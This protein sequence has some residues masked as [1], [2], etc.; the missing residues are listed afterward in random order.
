MDSK[1]LLGKILQR[2]FDKK[3]AKVEGF[4]SFGYIRET[5]NSVYVTRQT[6]EDTPIPFNKIIV[7][8]VAYQS[9]PELYETNPTALREFGITRVTSPI[10][11]LLHLLSKE[12]YE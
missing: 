6:G 7:G 5:N 10:F 9:N 12:D 2:F 11:A 1:I 3:I 8:I 4:Y